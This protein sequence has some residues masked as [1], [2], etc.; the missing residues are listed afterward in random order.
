ME[1]KENYSIENFIKAVDKKQTPDSADINDNIINT[2]ICWMKFFDNK[3]SKFRNISWSNYFEIELNGTQEKFEKAVQ[4]LSK[5]LT[6]QEGKEW[7][8]ECKT[9]LNWLVKKA[10][11][12]LRKYK[13]DGLTNQ[14]LYDDTL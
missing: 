13:S 7:C 3:T 12:S 2:L 5:D 9:K 14:D 10:T 8:Q 4:K 1:I 11:K 6:V